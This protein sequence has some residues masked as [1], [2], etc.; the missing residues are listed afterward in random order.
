MTFGEVSFVFTTPPEGEVKEHD[1]KVAQKD[2]A[3][4]SFQRSQKLLEEKIADG[5]VDLDEATERIEQL[6][7]HI[8]KIDTNSRTECTAFIAKHLQ[9]IIGVKAIEPDQKFTDEF[10]ISN[11]VP[12]ALFWQIYHEIRDAGLD[13]ELE[14]QAAKNS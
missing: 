13:P 4:K 7:A 3:L 5:K 6:E 10:L 2:K 9:S 12:Q 8:E 1:R 11:D 14:G